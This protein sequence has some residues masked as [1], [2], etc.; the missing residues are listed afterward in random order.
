MSG[1]EYRIKAELEA[2]GFTVEL[3][4]M[5][6]REDIQRLLDL[7]AHARNAAAAIICRQAAGVVEIW[8]TDKVTNKSVLRRVTIP[9]EEDAE[10]FVA[11]STMELLRASLL[12]IHTVAQLQGTVQ[13]T[14]EI[15]QLISPG[16]GDRRSLDR[17]ARKGIDQFSVQINPALMFI[18][19][20]GNPMLNLQIGASYIITGHFEF[21]LM[22]QTPIIP[23]A[24]ETQQGDIFVHSGYAQAGFNWILVHP[25]H[26][27]SGDIGLGMAV[28]TYRITGQALEGNIGDQRTFVTGAPMLT[29]GM[30]GRLVGRLR[31]RLET[32]A[33]WPMSKISI[34]VDKERVALLEHFFFSIGLGL[35]FMI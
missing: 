18:R 24:I 22:G 33:G 3:V 25:K 5:D 31:V 21:K 13:P 17:L 12:E 23:H 9:D 19:I 16:E 4:M 27:A 32:A 10:S 15:E 34:T 29:F 28:V 1:F 20:S 2:A 6:F 35:M 14:P 7:K 26:M 30:D 8:I 11:I